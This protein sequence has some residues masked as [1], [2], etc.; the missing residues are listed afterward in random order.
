M[1]NDTPQSEAPRPKVGA[2]FVQPQNDLLRLSRVKVGAMLFFTL[3]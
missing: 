2:S 3:P 1:E